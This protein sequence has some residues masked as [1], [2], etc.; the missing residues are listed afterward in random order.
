MKPHTSY[1][2]SGNPEFRYLQVPN[3]DFLCTS[4][5]FSEMN[6]TEND[7]K[8]HYANT[9]LYHFYKNGMTLNLRTKK[10]EDTI[11]YAE[12]PDTRRLFIG[13]SIRKVT[14][15]MKVVGYELE[16]I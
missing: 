14:S 1:S 4:T 6:I 9:T 7:P 3:S 16:K 10:G 8:Y 13:E 2:K 15:E 11:V 12:S 5:E